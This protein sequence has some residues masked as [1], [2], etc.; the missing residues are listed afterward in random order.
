MNRTNNIAPIAFIYQNAKAVI[1]SLM[2]LVA[3]LIPFITNEYWERVF[4]F[5]FISTALA[6]SW[7]IIGGYA[8]CYSFG[9]SVFFAVGAFASAILLTKFGLNFWIAI[10]GSGLTASVLSILFFPILRAKGFYFSMATLGTLLAMQVFFRQIP[11]LQSS[12]IGARGWVVPSVGSLSFFYY[13][14][15]S[16]LIGI[17]IFVFFGAKTKTGY[18]VQALR[19]DEITASCM[20]VWTTAYKCIA[21]IIA[22][23]WAGVIGGIYAPFIAYIGPES[24]F[25]V[26]W[27]LDMVVMTLLGGAGTVSGPIIGGFTLSLINQIVWANFLYL[28]VFIYGILITLIVMFLPHGLV[29]AIEV[30]VQKIFGMKG[31]NQG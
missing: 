6:Q 29:A 27:T 4:V 11:F 14:T 1:L 5:I 10:L 30:G 12:D 2:I 26:S 23:F 20:G 24:T 31:L 15:L 7:N 25:E 13:L 16:I 17:S 22:A 28:H 21:L 9:H 18:G 3:I 19:Q 8:G